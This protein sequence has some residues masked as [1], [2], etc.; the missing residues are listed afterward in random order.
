MRH[1]LR[2]EWLVH[3]STPAPG[4]SDLVCVVGT[5][6]G[7][8]CVWSNETMGWAWPARAAKG[9]ALPREVFDQDFQQG[10]PSVV[11][12][13]GRQPRLWTTDLRAPEAAWSFV[14]HASSIAHV[15]SV[16]AHQV[17]VAG[18]ESAMALYDLRFATAAARPLVAFAGYR[19][20]AHL[21]TGWDVSPELGVV[22]AAHDDGTVQ[23]FS[24]RSGRRLGG[25]ALGGVR[26]AAPVKALMF[27]RMPGERLP[28]LFVGVGPALAKYSFGAAGPDDEA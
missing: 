25:G 5:N 2:D 16:N 6:A 18:P 10:N 28:S 12:A 27:Q 3:G 22:A 20:A 4:G 19:N 14:R 23:L 21:H 24:L 13:G 17:L 15:R 1:G 7:V 9:L 8:L 26:A 11:L